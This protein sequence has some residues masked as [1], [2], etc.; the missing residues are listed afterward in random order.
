ME[1]SER[2]RGNPIGPT[3]MIVAGNVKRIRSALGITQAQLSER[4]GQLG[5]PIPIASV[6]KIETGDRKV[7]IDDFMAI[8][9]ALDVSPLALLLPE[10]RRPNEQVIATGVTSDAVDL[11][12]WGA[13]VAPLDAE[14]DGKFAGRSMPFWF[15][16]N[17]GFFDPRT[18][19]I[20]D[21]PPT[22]SRF[23]G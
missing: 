9:V 19:R 5:R 12:L 4:L 21:E 11:W 16:T 3:G 14:D 18:G 7:E 6:G 10:T 22:E 13:G 2:Q 15:G 23:D 1:T 17:A 20:A 8:A